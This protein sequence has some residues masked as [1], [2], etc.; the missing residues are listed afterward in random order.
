MQN[1]KSPGNHELTKQFFVTFWEDIKYAFLKF[2]LYT[3][4]KKE[5][6]ASQRKAVIKLIEKK[7]G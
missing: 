2:M 3:K 7:E 4:L 5:L 1:N 6:R